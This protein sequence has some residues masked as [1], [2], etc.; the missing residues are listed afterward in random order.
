MSAFLRIVGLVLVLLAPAA[1]AAP[2][3]GQPPPELPP[4]AASILRNLRSL[5]AGDLPRRHQRELRN[6]RTLVES[7]AAH[8]GPGVPGEVPS[9]GIARWGFSASSTTDPRL[10][11]LRRE[12]VEF[13]V[14]TPGIDPLVR[15]P[16]A[17]AVRQGDEPLE[18]ALT[19]L[20]RLGLL[21][22]AYVALRAVFHSSLGLLLLL[23]WLRRHLP[24]GWPGGLGR[25][26]KVLGTRAGL[27]LLAV[28]EALLFRGLPGL[29]LVLA[30]AVTA[31]REATRPEPPPGDAF[32]ARFRFWSNLYS[33]V[34]HPTKNLLSEV[35]R[36]DPASALAWLERREQRE[37]LAAMQTRLRD[38][39][40][41]GL[42][43]PPELAARIGPCS[44]ALE[45]LAADL[46]ASNLQKA[47]EAALD[48]AREAAR[49]LDGH[50]L[51]LGPDLLDPLL[52][53]PPLPGLTLARGEW[54]EAS[55]GI[56]DPAGFAAELRAI[57]S[58][59]L[60]N[61][62]DAGSRRVVLTLDRDPERRIRLVVDD[63]GPEEGETPAAPAS[64][65]GTGLEG[66][67]RWAESRGG[68]LAAGPRPEGGFRVELTLEAVVPGGRSG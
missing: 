46:S 45:R 6:I 32:T 44:F 55:L 35:E 25:A 18:D 57:L 27:T 9:D 22:V 67:A 42:P 34:L 10:R 49:W 15:A 62:R 54:V 7:L 51:R 3:A 63:D 56:E 21:A 5:E 20:R 28:I 37:T 19:R 64:A 38:A 23:W 59:L 61:S 50:R 12:L 36:G 24:E 16:L 11:A 40:K 60:K 68:R 47:H 48:L 30:V 26:M 29:L 14:E 66:A 39:T 13:L 2:A 65:L 17:E 41:A 52:A 1:L 43:E 31:R 53:A 8:H 33:T 58:D 4:K